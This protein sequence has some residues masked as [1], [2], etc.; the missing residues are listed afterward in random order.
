MVAAT[1]AFPVMIILVSKLRWALSP[2]I[3]LA[4]VSKQV[5]F[6]NCC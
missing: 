6:A 4:T 1:Q 5:L 2:N 3:H